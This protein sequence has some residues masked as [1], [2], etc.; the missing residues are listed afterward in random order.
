[1]SIAKTTFKG[2]EQSHANR[3]SSEQYRDI[4]MRAMRTEYELVS[5]PYLA[6]VIV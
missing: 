2:S 4:S 6:A 1:M 5:C 3:N